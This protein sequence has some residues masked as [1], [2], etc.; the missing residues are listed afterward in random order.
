M[1]KR[2]RARTLSREKAQR[3]A[4]LLSLAKSLVLKGKIQTTE[5]KA[6]EAARVV[7]KLVTVAKKGNLASRRSFG[8][9]TRQ[10]VEALKKRAETMK[11][12]PGG[13][14]RIM[15]LGPRMSNGAKMAVIEFVE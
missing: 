4:L 9:L 1:R 8:S 3:D 6:R 14:T 11:T 5:A 10:E 7:E 2:I 12:R 13:Y 15:K